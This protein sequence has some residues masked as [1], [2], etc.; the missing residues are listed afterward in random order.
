MG[1]GRFDSVSGQSVDLQV[2]DSDTAKRQIAQ[3]DEVKR[4]KN[5]ANV[6]KNLD[7]R[8]MK[9]EAKLA[10]KAAKAAK[11]SQKRQEEPLVKAAKK[12]EKQIQKQEQKKKRQ[13]GQTGQPGQPASTR[14]MTKKE[15]SLIKKILANSDN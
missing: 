1:G 7:K 11:Y 4:Q 9:K 6:Q 5:A 12:E 3:R 10:R 13:P 2:K 15:I 8:R 14:W